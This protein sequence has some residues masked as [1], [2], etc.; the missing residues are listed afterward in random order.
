MLYFLLGEVGGT[1]RTDSISSGNPESEKLAKRTKRTQR[2]WLIVSLGRDRV[3]CLF[4][5]R[6]LADR[7]RRKTSQLP[8]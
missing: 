6:E 3:G 2:A 7:V 5:A 1:M 8:S 4:G